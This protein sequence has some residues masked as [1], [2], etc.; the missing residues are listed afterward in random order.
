M[1]IQSF[2]TEFLHLASWFWNLSIL[3]HEP[4]LHFF[5]LSSNAPLYIY[6]IFCS[7]IHQ[8]TDI[9]VVCSLNS[10]NIAAMS[11]HVR[12]FVW[13]FAFISLGCVS[14]TVIA[15]SCGSS[16]CNL[17]RNCQNVLQSI[18]TIVYSN[19]KYKRVPVFPHPHL[20][21]VTC[22]FWFEPS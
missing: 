18:C 13:T 5:L 17:L 12:I 3:W 2:V 16:I 15:G 19:L 8:L 22:L 6:A 11:I 1:K 20:T 14:G 9:W 7:P 21:V 4:V 10:M